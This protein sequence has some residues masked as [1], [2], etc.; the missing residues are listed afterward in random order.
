MAAFDPDWNGADP[1]TVLIRPGGEVV[2]K[3]QGPVDALELKR[4]ILANLPDDN[5]YKGFQAYW[6]ASVYG[7]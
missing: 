4:I 6:H 5:S 7:K 1:Y 2:Y 3:M